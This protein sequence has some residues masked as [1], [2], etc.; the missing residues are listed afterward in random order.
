MYI[1][2]H[3]CDMSHNTPPR[4]CVPSNISHCNTLQH[5]ATHCNTL[6]HAATHCNTLQY[7]SC[8]THA[9]HAS[10]AERTIVHP[11]SIHSYSSVF[12]RGLTHS[13]DIYLNDLRA[14]LLKGHT[15]QFI[16][17]CMTMRCNMMQHAATR[18]NTLQHAATR[19]NTTFFT[20]LAQFTLKRRLNCLIFFD[21]PAK[22]SKFAIEAHLRV[23]SQV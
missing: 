6:Q 19:C 11:R 16:K 4:P 15:L 13:R 1:M 18:C 12:I 5:T 3:T 8:P 17:G 14:H 20:Y 7:T 2:S 23:M 21:I 22:K 10:K 9:I